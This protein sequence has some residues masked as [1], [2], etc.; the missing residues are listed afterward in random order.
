MRDSRGNTAHFSCHHFSPSFTSSIS[1][2]RYRSSSSFDKEVG[3]V[4]MRL[5]N[6]F[7]DSDDVEPCRKES[8]ASKNEQKSDL[9]H[10]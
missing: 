8:L 7:V 1:A 2:V 9:L 10:V 4:S 3:A 6:I 5:S